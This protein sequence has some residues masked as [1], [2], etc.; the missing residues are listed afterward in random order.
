MTD[1]TRALPSDALAE[2]YVLAAMIAAP[3]VIPAVQQVIQPGDFYQPRHETICAAVY[4]LDAAG[5]PVDG[6]SVVKALRGDLAGIGGPAYIHDLIAQMPAPDAATFHAKTVARLAVQRRL[7][8]AGT[9]LTQLGYAPD[10]TDDLPALLAAAEAEVDA[11][12]S[13]AVQDS[14]AVRVGDVLDDYL[15]VLETGEEPPGIAF[16]TADLR[17]DL[18]PLR[19]GS[20][21][22]IAA[23]SGIGKS[24]ASWNYAA[25]AAIHEKQTVLFHA[26]EMSRDEMLDRL[27]AAEAKV[28]Y[29]H[30]TSRKMTG[31]DWE[32]VSTA[33]GR[34]EDAPLFIDDTEGVSLAMLRASVRRVKPDLL[35]VDQIP[36]M[37]P[38]DPRAPREQQVAAISYGLKNLARAENVAVLAVAQ[39]N[40]EALKR[41]DK[42]PTMHDL[43]ESR[44]I[45]HAAD[46]V[47]LLHDEA[48]IEKES[49]RAGEIDWIV[50]KQRGGRTTTVTLANQLAFQRHVDMAA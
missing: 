27:I 37:T 44:A 26:L 40:D 17:R 46:L 19:K 18:R 48:H 14:T 41:S 47:V 6:A 42:K 9:R 43:R 49:P 45:V 12:A 20:L 3:R 22:V 16:H 1:D 2:Q 4:R 31:W 25:H 35:V 32:K 39:L 30:I 21:A 5:E 50:V 38:P 10:S 29:G 7:I 36:I 28:D 8:T 11:V 34:I 15:E 13:G 33:R 24:I 23:W